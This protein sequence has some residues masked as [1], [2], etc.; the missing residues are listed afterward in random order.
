M[1]NLC[2]C[3]ENGFSGSQILTTLILTI[4]ITLTYSGIRAIRPR[5]HFL[6]LS[7]RNSA[8]LIIWLGWTNPQAPDGFF[9]P[10]KDLLSVNISK[11]TK[12]SYSLNTFFCSVLA[13][14]ESLVAPQ[15]GS[16]SQMS[17]R[18][19]DDFII[20]SCDRNYTLSGSATLQCKDGAWS[21]AP[22]TCQ[23]TK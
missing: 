23:A 4:I 8:F 16:I 2:L 20:F 11:I 21:N 1:Q 3:W 18:K 9:P 15:H 19:H 13:P 10:N 12:L 7:H 6:I 22:P 17:G 5:K 14:C